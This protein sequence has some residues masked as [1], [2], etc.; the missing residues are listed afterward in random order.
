MI[1]LMFLLSCVEAHGGTT[2]GRAGLDDVDIDI[3]NDN[4]SD[5]VHIPLLTKSADFQPLHSMSYLVSPKNAAGPMI[6]NAKRHWPKL[7]I[8]K[9]IDRRSYKKPI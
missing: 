9:S 4:D 3:D 5:N 2:Q 6:R 7:L 1:P 8:R